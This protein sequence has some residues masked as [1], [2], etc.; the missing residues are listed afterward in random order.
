MTAIPASVAASRPAA[1]IHRCAAQR[2]G[3]SCIADI[4]AINHAI[5]QGQENVAA[6]AP[7][8]LDLGD[9]GARKSSGASIIT[10]PALC[11]IGG[12]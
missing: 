1:R 2:H 9:H 8:R 10:S 5:Q 12:E 4:V 6:L 3:A 11:I 7:R